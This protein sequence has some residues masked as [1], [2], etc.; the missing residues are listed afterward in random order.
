MIWKT[1]NPPPNAVK[2]RKRKL[3]PSTRGE[4]RD[5]LREK[6]PTHHQVRA[7]KTEGKDDSPGEKPRRTGLHRCCVCVCVLT[8]WKLIHTV[9]DHFFGTNTVWCKQRGEK[10]RSHLKPFGEFLFC[11]HFSLPSL[12]LSLFYSLFVLCCIIAEH[13]L[14]HAVYISFFLQ[15]RSLAVRLTLRFFLS[16]SLFALLT[17]D[18]LLSLSFPLFYSLYFSVSPPFSVFFSSL[19][20]PSSSRRSPENI[21][22]LLSL[23]AFRR[24]RHT[25][26]RA[27]TALNESKTQRGKKRIVHFNNLLKSWW[28]MFSPMQSLLIT[29]WWITDESAPLVVAVAQHW[30]AD[31]GETEAGFFFFPRATHCWRRVCLHLMNHPAII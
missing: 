16:R 21:S 3:T 8:H 1:L 4:H 24:R 22:A 31:K 15:K 27:R 6:H 5:S 11:T 17:S 26:T 7:S 28:G 18:L 12:K 29:F 13:V 20:L 14:P 9:F 30:Y 23:P 19:A 10:S 2:H 25:H